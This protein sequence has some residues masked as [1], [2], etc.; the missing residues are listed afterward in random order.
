MKFSPTPGALVRSARE[1]AGYTLRDLGEI[2]GLSHA[3]L[4]DVEHGRRSLARDRWAAV[5]AAL[6][7]LTVR[8]IAVATVA[9][10]DRGNVTV[11]VTGA[12]DAE[13]EAVTALLVRAAKGAA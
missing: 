6:P 13:I 7:S 10:A 1:A 5:C 8:D 12:S 2:L 11:N 3:H 9:H 4:C